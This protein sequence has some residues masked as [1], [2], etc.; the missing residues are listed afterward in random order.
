MAADQYPFDSDHEHNHGEPLSR[1]D[2]LRH[3]TA[4]I[5]GGGAAV[6]GGGTAFAQ[7]P[8]AAATVPAALAGWR[9]ETA[10]R[11]FRALVRYRTNLDVQTLTLNPIQ[12]RQVV[13]RVEA[14][15][16]CYTMVNALNTSTPAM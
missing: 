2:L 15:Q 1:R 7:A 4:A 12:P 8:A 6:L 9:P 11:R 16:A 3:G 5:I 10:G 13:T 14:A